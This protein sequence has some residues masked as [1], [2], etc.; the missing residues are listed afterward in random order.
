MARQG[1]GTGY[2]DYLSGYGI[3]R[4]PVSPVRAGV[5]ALPSRAL[6]GQYIPPP[7][8]NLNQTY[9]A[10]NASEVP[11]GTRPINR[12]NYVAPYHFDPTDL[13]LP[14][15]GGSTES[16]LSGMEQIADR[17]NYTNRAHSGSSSVTSL[18]G[19]PY[20]DYAAAAMGSP[21][22]P[23][24]GVMTGPMTKTPDAQDFLSLM[25]WLM[26]QAGGR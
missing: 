9:A 12:W 11:A 14:A 15:P 1:G 5:D 25:Q 17:P 19:S 24:A 6:G 26:T 18:T 21:V 7:M 4:V 13:L 20:L 22:D 16:H 23:M 3:G 8:S 10:K 2:Q